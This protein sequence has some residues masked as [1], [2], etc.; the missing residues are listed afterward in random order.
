MI[1]VDYPFPREKIPLK[2]SALQMFNTSPSNEH[3]TNDGRDPLNELTKFPCT[4]WDSCVKSPE[5]SREDI[6]DRVKD[7]MEERSIS[8]YALYEMTGLSHKL[9]ASI[10]DATYDLQDSEPISKLESALGIRLNHL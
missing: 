7:A 4:F 6:A 9:V 1:L 10:L 5:Q 2:E 8:S 3:D